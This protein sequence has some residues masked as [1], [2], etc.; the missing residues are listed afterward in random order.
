MWTQEMVLSICLC[1]PKFHTGGVPCGGWAGDQVPTAPLAR[2]QVRIEL[3]L[4]AQQFNLA[5]T[6]AIAEKRILFLPQ[7]PG[8]F[9]PENTLLSVHT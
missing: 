1:P 4:F 3:A 7:L 2:G 6:S 9:H 5:D 8:I